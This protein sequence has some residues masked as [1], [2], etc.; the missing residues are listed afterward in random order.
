MPNTPHR[1]SP[2]RADMLATRA[3]EQRRRINR[4]TPIASKRSLSTRGE[5]GQTWR[6]KRWTAA[7]WRDLDAIEKPNLDLAEQLDDRFRPML[8]ILKAHLLSHPNDTTARV[9]LSKARA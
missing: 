5:P 8:A 7:R 4:V 3:E 2:E 1:N 9:A 6:T